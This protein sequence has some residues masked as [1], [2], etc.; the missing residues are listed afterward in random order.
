MRQDQSWKGG[1]V[2]AYAVP[3]LRLMGQAAQAMGR[4]EAATQHN[5]RAMTLDPHDAEAVDLLA[6]VRF[7]QQ[8]YAAALDL[9]RTLVD[10]RPSGAQ[11]H[12]NLRVTL[13]YPWTEE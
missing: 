7:G 3:L 8:R 6:M 10:L 11:G 12:S 9:F 13:F 5:E 2:P 1:R 4:I